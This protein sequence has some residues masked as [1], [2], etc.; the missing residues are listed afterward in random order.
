LLSP[1]QPE[2]DAKGSALPAKILS[3]VG[4]GKKDE[5]KTERKGTQRALQNSV[6]QAAYELLTHLLHHFNNF[7]PHCGAERFD[8]FLL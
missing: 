6:Q 3:S 1:T 7:P 2:E 5:Q 8:R 4:G